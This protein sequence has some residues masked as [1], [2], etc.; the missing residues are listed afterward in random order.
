[1]RKW[2]PLDS[3]EELPVIIASHGSCGTIDN[4]VSLYRELASHGYTVLAVCHPGQAANVQ[5]K[6]GYIY[7]PIQYTHIFVNGLNIKIMLC[8]WMKTIHSIRI[9]ITMESGIW[10]CVICRSHH[11]FCQS[12]STA[13]FRMWMHIHSLKSSM[14]IVLNG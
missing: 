5:Y 6:D 11:R 13:A 1:M 10:D 4:N 3:K 7:I 2:H 14:R 9:F 12:Y 8:F